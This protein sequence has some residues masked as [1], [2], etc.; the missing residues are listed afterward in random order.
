[1]TM[2]NDTLKLVTFSLG[3]D[4]YATDIFSVERVLR[5]AAPRAVPNSPAWLPG[6]IDHEGRVVPVIDLRA[7]FELPA[8]APGAETRIIVFDVS[9]Q[10][11]AAVVDTVLAV[12]TVTP[13][14]IE[15]PPPLFRGLTRDYL[16]GLLRQPNGV[17]V[18]LN[19]NRLLTSQERLV[20][21]EAAGGTSV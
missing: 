1:M 19:A 12:V 8:A 16:T 18:V 20:L 4:L 11:V 17:V 13:D 3:G 6:V 14:D 2:A 21:E 7:R 15:E 10:W 5:Y 9:G